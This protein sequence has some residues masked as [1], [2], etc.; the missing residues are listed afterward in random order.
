MRIKH[1]YHSGVLLENEDC[2]I[3]VDAIK[4]IPNYKHQRI[5][6]FVTHSHGDHYASDI[7]KLKD[8]NNVTYIVSEDVP[9]IEDAIVVKKGHEM[10]LDLMSFKVFGTTDLGV[11][12]LI[13]FEDYNI[14]HSGDL[15]W[16]HWPENTVEKQL[17]EKRQYEEE[18]KELLGEKID[19]AFVPVDPRLKEGSRFAMD[20]FIEKLHPNVFIPIHFGS[21][22]EFIQTIEAKHT[23]LMIPTDENQY[24]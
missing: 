1:L 11:S 8:F 12:Y 6:C 13:G 14:F 16:W 20:Y 18:I 2:I 5:F 7:L 19:Y 23:I 3:L 21:Q 10:K 22:Y 4:H 9:Y 15:N 24:L 17:D